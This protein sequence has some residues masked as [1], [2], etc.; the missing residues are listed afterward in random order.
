MSVVRTHNIYI[1]S[2]LRQ[3]GTS[4]DFVI[5]LK[6]P[7]VLLNQKN[8]FRIRLDNAI[9]PHTIK[10]V[11]NTNNT[12]Q[13]TLVRTGVNYNGTISLAVGNYNILTLITELGNKLS[14]SIL[15]NTSISVIF[16][17][18]SYNRDT[19]YATLVMTGTDNIATSLTLRFGSDVSL[20]KMFG[21]LSDITLSYNSSN[22]STT[23][24]STRN[25]NVNPI[26]Y[27]TIRSSTLKQRQNYES[28]VEKD[29]YAD[30]I[31]IV[32]INVN[33]GSFIIHSG[34][35]PTDIVNRVLDTIELYLADNLSY[36][37][38]LYGLEWSC[39]LVIEEIGVEERDELLAD[40][41]A[42]SKENPTQK[43]EEEK[44]RMLQ[45]LDGMRQQYLD[46]LSSN[47]VL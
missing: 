19:G 32:P 16:T 8:F 17:N 5:N 12:L 23:I 2:A 20:G 6:R 1:N 3:S 18:S 40:S 10:Q 42:M 36:A 29:V 22:V 4:D 39:N 21:M 33:P 13:Y 47:L 38:S 28:I 45:E 35:P 31:A 44:Q 43:L 15:A 34:S 37:I 7:L 25:V 24:T 27:L 9:I 26:T 41:A 11:N 30:I 46:N 14:S